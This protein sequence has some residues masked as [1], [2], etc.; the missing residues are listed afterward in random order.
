MRI[1]KKFLKVIFP[2]VFLKKAFLILNT[3]KIRTID[4]FL[5]NTADV[6]EDQFLLRTTHTP[7][8]SQTFGFNELAGRPEH[9]FM[10]RWHNWSE[11]IYVLKFD[12]QCVIEPVYGWAIESR[13][14]LIYESLAYAKTNHQR[15]PSL[16][17]YWFRRNRIKLGTA[18]S[19]RD[20]GEENY[21]HF[22]NDILAKIPF[23]KGYGLIN[24]E[25]PLII[26]E[27]LWS[28]TYFQ[29]YLQAIPEAGSLNWVIQKDEH[30]EC[31]RVIF[32][33]VPTHNRLLLDSVFGPL[34]IER[35]GSRLVFV[36]RRRERLRFID[37][38]DEIG[39]ICLEN[40]IELI[41]AADL[42]LVG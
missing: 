40:G 9:D 8:S 12:R 31:E 17:S 36:T 25:M 33:K 38:I 32:C 30:V 7:F 20:T 23:L 39:A 22:Y 26:S 15:K 37:N 10:T 42:S 34:K 5:F 18:V 4:R 14:D 41:D 1:A 13:R 27:K 28:K 35:T 29:Y 2:I 19:L 3:F 21:F 24:A 16:F 6:T 11:D